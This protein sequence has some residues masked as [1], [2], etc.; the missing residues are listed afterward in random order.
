MPDTHSLPGQA[1]LRAPP[2]A[3]RR[4]DRF[5]LPCC[6][7]V[8]GSPWT[9]RTEKRFSQRV[10]ALLDPA[11]RGRE[12]RSPTRANTGPVGAQGRCGHWIP[13]SCPFLVGDEVRTVHLSVQQILTEQPAAP[14][15]RPPP[16][17]GALPAPPHLLKTVPRWMRAPK[18]HTVRVRTPAL[19]LRAAWEE[20]CRLVSPCGRLCPSVLHRGLGGLSCG[21][22]AP[23]GPSYEQTPGR[24]RIN[25]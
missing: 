6:P 18:F 7:S 14:W 16:T 23:A 25:A 4:V 13:L 11:H 12:H 8:H 22:T 24:G 1:A 10:P 21:E 17:A 5:P 3:G 15:A 20:C 19:F 9:H 2:S